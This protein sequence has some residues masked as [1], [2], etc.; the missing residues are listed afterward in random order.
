MCPVHSVNDVSGCSYGSPPDEP[1]RFNDEGP[2]HRVTMGYRF[3]IG[4]YAVTVGEYRRFVEATGH[5]H[6]GGIYVLS[7]SAWKMD[8]SKSWRDPGFAQT[9]RHPVVGVSWQDVQAYLE[10]LSREAGQ[11]YRL[12]S[13]AE[14]EYACRAGTTTPFSFGKTMTSDQANYDG[15]YT[16]AGS[17]KGVYRKRTVEVGGLPANPWGLHEMHGNVWEWL[18]DVWHDSYKGAPTDGSAWIDGEGKQS[19]R[20]RAVRGGSWYNLPWYCR[21]AV[22]N[23]NEP[24]TRNVN[25]GCRLSRTVS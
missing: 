11:V 19:S 10:W 17:A 24:V 6:S 14:W 23:R 22:R 8:A 21:S 13:E 18:E 1:E 12:P 16:Y 25:L 5:D 9:D 20:S 2:Q 3:A 4:R 15:N 7:G